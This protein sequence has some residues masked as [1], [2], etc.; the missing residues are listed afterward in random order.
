MA[1]VDPLS[2]EQLFRRCDPARFEFDTT[3]ELESLDRVIGQERAEE[4]IRFAIGMKR[5]GYNLYALGAP[6][7]GKHTMVLD[8][9]R[10]AA[11]DEAT[12]ADWCYVNNFATPHK[13]RAM[14]LPAGR[15]ESFRAGMER[16]IEELRS[17]IPA[18]FESDEYRTRRQLI[19]GE[20]KERSE[21][22]FEEVQERA[23]KRGI[24]LMR[25]PMGLALAPVRGEEVLSP[26][27]F[28]KL[29]EEEQ[30]RVKTDIEELQKTLQETLHKM[31]VWEKEQR[32]KIRELNHEVTGFA[33]GHL[34]DA[35]REDF[36]D[37]ESVL[38]YFEE[39]RGDVI[40]NAL[41]FLRE[42]QQAQG[43]EQG[44]TPPPPGGGTGEAASFRRYRVNLIVDNGGANGSPV[45]YEDN[46][47][48]P[49][50]VGRVEHSSQ[51]GALVTDFNLIKPGALHRANGGYLVF[52]ARRLLM[53]P[54]SWEEMKRTL[55]AGKIRIE[56]AGQALSLVS[57]ISLEPEPIPL[58]VKIV[59]IGDRTLYYLL[60]AYDPDFQALFK[61]P[62][63]FDDS[64]DLTDE[65]SALYT[66]L[67]ATIARR[68]ELRPLDR[69]G[70]ARVIEHAARLA[71]DSEKLTTEVRRVV[72]LLREADYWA[73]KAKNKAIGAEHVQKAI[74]AQIYRSDR[75]RERVHEEIQRG[76]I[77]IET[78][79]E[80]VGQVNGLSVMQLDRVSFGKP[81]RITARVRLGKGEVIDIE[82]QVELGGPLHSKG[83][84][85]LAG[86][87]GARFASERPLPLSASLVFEQS[88][89][90]VDG[91]S[92]S[93]AELYALL[94]ALSEAPIKQGLAVTGSVNQHG[95][96]QA[97]G[98]V[99]E[100]IEGFFGV[101]RAKGLTGEQGV[102]IPQSNVKHLMLRHDVVAAVE[103]GKFRVFPVRTVDQGIELLT[104][105][106]AGE[107][108]ASG[109]YPDG[110][111]NQ[112][113]DARL[114]HFARIARS[115]GAG[116]RERENGAED[117]A[118]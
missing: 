86:F 89:G 71:G 28:G 23:K 72:D 39:V 5:E 10:R 117:T 99:N 92:A 88:Y 3:D 95:E 48:L 33:V 21:A 38:D 81:S 104:G 47:T 42:P 50:V 26:A 2:P 94:S 49:N 13:P 17:A 65:T 108:D 76:T 37:L 106:A 51:F 109:A 103:Q 44:Q 110:T 68:E 36:A 40:E 25:T 31:P 35:L 14:R 46:P 87:L 62:A 66:R 8:Y 15:A 55:R 56:S 100:K 43:R 93:S 54:L 24:A 67:V 12:P 112:R 102:L 97:I 27:D 61:V 82:R 4:A 113:V 115:F 84:L 1:Q 75:V 116:A 73:D 41:E 59:L 19:E 107:R 79:N 53:Q 85:I 7:T 32:E 77:L 64:T 80:V 91:D 18:T 22:A 105:I 90:G 45:I 114:A 16:L 30:A 20:F 78:E 52:D 60:S 9:L 74:D 83:V 29:P 111:I 63:D 96:V 58:E 118:P 11:T 98:G 69:S 34:I 57:T 101:C 70:V 6:G